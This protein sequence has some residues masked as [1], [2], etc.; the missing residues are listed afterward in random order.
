MKGVTIVNAPTGKRDENL[1]F[2]RTVAHPTR[3]RVSPLF[4]A[5]LAFLLDQQW[6]APAIAEIILTSDGHLL[7]RHEDEIGASFFPGSR[8]D[9]RDNIRGVSQVLGATRA[10]ELWLLERV[11][12]KL[13]KFARESSPDIEATL[14][15]IV[16]GRLFDLPDTVKNSAR[17]VLIGLRDGLPY[18]KLG[19]RVLSGSKQWVSFRLGPRYRLIVEKQGSTLR[20]HVLCTHERYND[21][22]PRLVRS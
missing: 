22:A 17:V 7:V 16:D 18:P 13:T 1:T 4:Q 11:E 6:T 12:G 20:P 14:A 5:V 3:L 10:Q 19:G 21:I 9:L 15:Q 2:W 8:E